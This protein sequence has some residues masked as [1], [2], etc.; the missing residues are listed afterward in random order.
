MLKKLPQNTRSVGKYCDYW[1][2][3]KTISHRNHMYLY[4][5]GTRGI[6]S[7]EVTSDIDF[8]DG[9]VVQLPSSM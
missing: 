8:A 7:D 9:A 2:K 4:G 5:N 3:R 1:E 6:I